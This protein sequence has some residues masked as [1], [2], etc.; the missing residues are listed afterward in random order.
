MNIIVKS[1]HVEIT[2]ALKDYADKKMSKLDHFNDHIQQITVN[3]QI[4]AASSINDQQEASAIVLCK[5]A[6]IKG[7][8][9]SDDMYSSID[10]LYD[11]LAIQLKKYKEKMKHHKGNLPANLPEVKRDIQPVKNDSNTGNERYIPKPMGPEDAAE[12]LEEEKLNF[13]VFRNL[14]EKICVIY[15]SGDDA[16]GL[17]VT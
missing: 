10:V 6:V 5:G 11:K 14:K 3:L 8:Q 16:Y 2:T 4:N 17:I 12:I 1:H 9:I 15:P 7:R 13:L